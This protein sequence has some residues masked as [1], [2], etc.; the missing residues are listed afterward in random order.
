[1]LEMKQGRGRDGRGVIN[2]EN[3]LYMMCK[4]VRKSVKL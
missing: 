2:V 3:Y 4:V 1:M